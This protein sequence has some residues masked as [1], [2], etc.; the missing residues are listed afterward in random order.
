ML[1]E[2]DRQEQNCL[3][4]QGDSGTNATA[5]RKVSWVRVTVKT[6]VFGLGILFYDIQ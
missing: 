6:Y 3:I 2:E 5:L 1:V 4:Q